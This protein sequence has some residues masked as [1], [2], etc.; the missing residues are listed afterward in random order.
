[1]TKYFTA[2]TTPPGFYEAPPAGTAYVEISDDEWRELL[3]QQFSGKQIIADK[4]EKPVAVDYI[5]VSIA[6][7]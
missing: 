2:E 4:D 1:M 7:G 5:P 6:E 3:E